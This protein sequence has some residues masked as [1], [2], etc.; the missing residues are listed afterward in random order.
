M[1]FSPL[2]ERLAVAGEQWSVGLQRLATW[3]AVCVPSYA[4]AVA[5]VAESLGLQVAQTTLWRVVQ[6]RGE[7]VQARRTAEARAAW[8]LPGRGLVV[9]GEVRRARSM[10]IGLDGVFINVRGEGWK[11]VKV[12]AVFEIEPLTAGEKQRRLRRHGQRGADE[13]EIR[14]M[15][16]ARRL[17]YSAYL[18]SVEEFEPYQW[19]EAQRR[20]LPQ[21]WD[22]LVIGDGAD[23]IDRIQQ[24]CYADA[25][26]VVDWYHA[27]EHLA[28]VAEQAWGTQAAGRQRWLQQR[29]DHLWRGEVHEVV[30]AIQQ[31]PLAESEKT[32]ASHYFR[33]HARAMNYLEFCEQGLPVGS[34]MV[35]GGGCKGVVEGRLK[36]V[37]MRWSRAGAQHMLALC[38]EYHSQRW[39]QVWAT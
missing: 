25:V 1:A 39:E 20:Q 29:K 18:G 31:L 32:R 16:K 36:G 22:T 12:A 17:S 21:C 27:C 24:Q 35:E 2:D 7:A 26:R 15:V 8:A 19:A 13:C 28:A 4:K 23:W 14:D 11:E 33:E 38:C 6:E 5:G 30:A 9:P 3:L 34:G 37:G 10:G